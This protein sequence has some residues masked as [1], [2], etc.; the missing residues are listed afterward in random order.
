MDEAIRSLSDKIET[1]QEK[2]RD[3]AS[4]FEAQVTSK[5][6]DLHTR[7]A[8]MEVRA[9]MWGGVIGFLGGGAAS[10]ILDVLIGKLT[11]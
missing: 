11:K 3:R 7:M 1:M 6:S 5:I 10:A 9:K 2:G 8:M 4:L